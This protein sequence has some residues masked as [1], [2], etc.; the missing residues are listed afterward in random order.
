MFVS[1]KELFFVFSHEQRKQF[2][3]LQILVTITALFEVVSVMM[4]APFM[5]L[6]SDTTILQHDGFIAWCYKM[7]GFHSP[8]KFVVIMGVFVLLILSLGTLISVLTTWRLARYSYGI[9]GEMSSQLYQYYMKQPWLFHTLNSSANLLNKT[10]ADTLR[11]TY[12]VIV[13]LMYINAK[14]FLVLFM[15]VAIL[16]YDPFVAITGFLV[17][18]FAYFSVYQLIKTRLHNSGEEVSRQ[19]EL[20]YRLVSEGLGGIK[21]LL[22]SNRQVSLTQKYT[23]GAK[24]LAIKRSDIQIIALAPRYMLELLTF[25]MLITVVFY[26]FFRNQHNN[27]QLLATLALY[28]LVGFKLLPVF[29]GIYAHFTLVKGGLP[30]F[31]NLKEDLQNSLKYCETDDHQ[32][33]QSIQVKQ[34]IEL[35]NISFYYPNTKK[36]ALSHINLTIPA[37]KTIGFVGESGSGKT[38]LIDILLA[39]HKP[40]TGKVM[41]D[42]CEINQNNT[43]AWQKNL[44]YIPQNIFLSD[45]S[46]KENIAFGLPVDAIC[47]Q[48]VWQAA[49]LAK[50]ETVINDLPNG[51]DTYVG[52]RGVQLSGGQR[53]R[54][55]IARALYQD[56]SM[57]VLD[58]ATSALDG[59]T[60][61]IIMDAIKS[62]SGNKTLII[63]AHRLATIQECDII[64]MMDKG[65][66]VDQGT[67]KELLIKNAKFRE[68]SQHS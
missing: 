5:M 27:S 36:P 9:G 14:V 33:T 44:G 40:S 47:E 63:I 24:K 55:G 21:T 39:L 56:A 54:I 52:E 6:V 20:L 65:R 3:T 50:L 4:I 67:F 61:K 1:L 42:D 32:T 59:L 17:L 7:G 53:Q 13:P 41:V 62:F 15:S 37:N 8:E 31:E 26:F 23:D 64:F 10:S 28:G 2:Y 22:L 66:V 12:E 18:S 35:N 43:V 58:E 48:Q 30:A 19:S 38:T 51:I 46:V 45:A 34:C 11:L 25:V 57:L 29:Q 16:I 60:E 68:M 49:K